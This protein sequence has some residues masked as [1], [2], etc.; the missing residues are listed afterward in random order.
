[1]MMPIQNSLNKLNR[2]YY[3]PRQGQGVNQY[4]S[5]PAMFQIQS[6]PRPWHQIP[7]STAIS[8]PISHTRAPSP[9]SAS[10]VGDGSTT[11]TSYVDNLYPAATSHVGGVGATFL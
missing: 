2:G 11:S 9:T 1:M 7:Q 10:H 4:P 6:F 5:W 3:L 8:V